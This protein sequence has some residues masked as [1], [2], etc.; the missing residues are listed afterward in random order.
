MS[1]ADAHRPEPAAPAPKRLRLMLPTQSQVFFF[2]ILA[3]MLFLT[4]VVF[5]GFIIYM[6]AGVF[7]AVLALPIDRMWEKLFPNRVA[8]VF[9][10]FTL[11]L[12]LTLPLAILG[13]SLYQ[14]ANDLVRAVDE[15]HLR[16]Y[17]NSTVDI[18]VEF[19]LL[20]EEDRNVTVQQFVAGAQ[21]YI[22]EA[23]SDLAD[24]LLS[25]VGRFF[26]AFTVIL[27]VV[28]YVL[29][30]GHRLTSYLRRATPLPAKQVDYLM[31]EA[32]RGLK[33]VFVG[34]ILTSVIQGAVGGIGFLIA[35]LPGVILWSAV[36][37][38]LSLL[39][40]VGAFL[41]WVPAA[42]FLLIRG[43]LWQGIFLLGWGILIVSQV[44]NFV[45]PKLIGD[46]SG[47]H[48]LFV[49][50][51]VLGGVAAFG[52]IGLFLGPLLVGVTVSVLKVWETDYLDPKV[53][54]ASEEPPSDG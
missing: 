10:I 3:L 16:D 35:G 54:E 36:M 9:T 40:V 50:V 47:I 28:Y 4:W 49:L 31:G 7:V 12:I 20:Q 53:L 39:P 19:G 29:T 6:V 46:R 5:R 30:D 1:K 2:T 41:V 26:V 14:D 34:Q 8:A 51:G 48:P 44:D 43:D 52:F 27:F 11:V 33:A 22:R 13:L 25:G 38:I 24:S 23:L 17:A 15:G 37:A 21:T 18:M 45:R 42:I 32:H